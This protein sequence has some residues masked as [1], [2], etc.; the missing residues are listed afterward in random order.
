MIPDV[1]RDEKIDFNEVAKYIIQRGVY[2]FPN[3]EDS[4]PLETRVISGN[5]MKVYVCNFEKKGQEW[6]YDNKFSELS[7]VK[8]YISD[9]TKIVVISNPNS[10]FFEVVEGDV[11]DL[12]KIFH[13]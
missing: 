2:P 5:G 11:S 13:K 7:A 10:S 9:E 1:Y 12:V 4:F 3:D 6:D 8:E